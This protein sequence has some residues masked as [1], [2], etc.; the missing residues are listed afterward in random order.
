LVPAT[1][2]SGSL[3]A[4]ASITKATIIRKIPA[5]TLAGNANAMTIA[6]VEIESIWIRRTALI[7]E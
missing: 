7:S 6:M 1:S 5:P 2:L 4:T 3:D